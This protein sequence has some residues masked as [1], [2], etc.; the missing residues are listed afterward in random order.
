MGRK[1]QSQI[2]AATS[3]LPGFEPDGQESA[4]LA[5]GQLLITPVEAAPP[6]IAAAASALVGIGLATATINPIALPDPRQALEVHGSDEQD[7]VEPEA[8]EAGVTT[9]PPPVEEVVLK[10]WPMFDSA[11]FEPPSGEEK[12][13]KTNLHAIALCK[14]LRSQSV[15]P[16]DAQRHELLTY[17]GWGGLARVFETL[18][19]NTLQRY[20]DQLTKMLTPEE[21]A[22]ARAS[23]TD[24]FYTDPV[25]V[26]AMWDIVQRMGFK[27][28][29]IVEPT[30]GT[31]MFLA[32]MPREIAQKSEITAVEMDTVSGEIL[33]TVFGGLGVKTHIDRIERANVPYGFYDLCISN[34]PFGEQKSLETRKVGYADFSL[35]NYVIAK[36]CDLVRA[37]GLVVVVTSRF[38]MD[39]Q[40]RMHRQWL[41]AHAELLGAIRLPR[42]AFKKQA[43]TDV[44]TDIIV[45]RKRAAPVFSDH[46]E[47]INLG[48]APMEIMRPG[49]SLQDYSSH[50]RGYV[51]KPR[52]INAY[53]EKHPGMVVGQLEFQSGRYG[54]DDLVPVFAG[55]AQ[56]YKARLAECV[57][58]MPAN[59]YEDAKVVPDDCLAP[60]GLLLQRTTATHQVKPG[61]FVLHRGAIHISEGDSW[62]DVDAAYKGAARERLLGLMRLR[63]A[64]RAL[65]Q[66]QATST[67]E[68]AFRSLQFQLNTVYDGFVAKYGHMSDRANVR[69]FR[70]DPECPLILSLEQFDEDEEVYRKA[71]IFTKR[72]VGHREPPAT[73]DTTRDAMLV[74]LAL[75]GRIVLPDMAK[76]LGISSRAVVQAIVDEALAYLDPEDGKWRPADEY[77]SGHIRNKIAIATAAGAKYLR[78]VAALTAVL[79]KDLGPGEVEVRLGAPWVPAGVLAQF[80][81]ELIRMKAGT[82]EVEYDA[83]SATWTVKSGSHNPEWAGDRTLNTAKWG[84]TDRCAVTL[85]E[86]A[87]NQSPPK[88]TRTGVDKKTYVDRQATLAAR[89]KFEAIKCEFKQWAY[90]DEARRDSLLRMYN[91]EFNQIVER[92]YDGSHL[93]L[94][95][96]SKVIDPYTHQLSAIWRIVSG[97]NTLLAHVVGGGKTFTMAAA[98]ME[99]R[100]IGKAAKPCMVV[101]NHMLYDFT[102]DVVRFYPNAKIL[103]ASK[104]DL[105][106]DKRREFVAR[107]ALGDWDAV[108]MTHSTFERLPLRP[109]TAHKFVGRL[110]EQARLAMNMA[111]EAGS[112]RTVKQ[113]EKLIKVFEAKIERAMAEGERD[114]F[115]YWDDLGI[116]MIEYDEAHAAKN[117]LR[118]SKM[119]SIAGL[120]NASS[121]RAFDLWMKTSLVMEQRGDKEE[122]VVLST[123]TPLSNSLAEMHVLQKYLQPYTLKRLGLY[124]FDS[125]A[126]T[127]GESTQSLELAPD[128]SG[129]RLQSRFAK[130]VNVADLMAI[131]RCVADIRTRKMVKLPTPR[132]KGGK[133]QVIASEASTALKAYV[134]ELVKRANA[135]RN[136]SVKP[137]EDNMLSITH[138]G[139]MA[140]LDMR[141]VDFRLP[142]DESG[143]VARCRDEVMRI[144]NETHDRRGTQ[145]VFCD[146]ST[147]HTSGFS[148]YKDLEEK[149][150]ATGMPPEQIEF[151][152]DHD[153]DAAKEALFKKVRA[154]VV[155]VL[156]GSTQKLGIGTNVQRRLKAVHSLD[157]PWRPA[158]L[159]Q[160]D[161][162]GERPGNTWDEIE[163]LRYVTTSSFDAYIYQLIEAKARFIE[164][165]MTSTSGLR[166][167]EDLTVGAL[168]YAEIKAIASGNPVVLE[169]ATID[170]QVLRYTVLQDQHE[171]D[172]WTWSRRRSSNTAEIDHIEKY[173]DSDRADAQAI[174]AEATS[175]WTFQPTGTPCE[176]AVKAKS[177]AEQIGAQVNEVHKRVKI[178]EAVVGTVAGMNLVLSRWDGVQLYVASKKNDRMQ[179]RIDRRGVY[180]TQF[181][182]TGELVLDRLRGLIDLPQARDERVA[183]LR[184]ENDDLGR[185][186]E[187][188]FEHSDKLRDLVARQREIEAVLD[189]D[190]NEAGTEAV[191]DGGVAAETVA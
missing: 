11:L 140:A 160:R 80:L 184:K 141:L 83:Q 156:M 133:A 162:R 168:S 29:R 37:G 26:G 124:E 10:A 30:S 21:F 153:S 19:R 125:W 4:H 9:E 183:Q 89:E 126:G 65:L 82:A 99:M 66:Q 63:D 119:P 59:I 191:P 112:K 8:I 71:D 24:A 74:S 20:Q 96:M 132:I 185:M 5:P 81:D 166:T 91:D 86:N 114:D 14:Q 43:G 70:S 42:N 38:T 143:K 134:K 186:L 118:I 152:H 33:E 154:G 103:M 39:S 128:G 110:I 77:L 13:I 180:L 92:V 102:A 173:R 87:L 15:E 109:T 116:D 176:A 23:T 120:P 123:A 34:V 57:E 113:C 142:F 147:P 1:S 121:N 108:I 53:Y 60:A 144:W 95:G 101:P 12:R 73:V 111:N 139:R 72:T 93:L 16:T 36:G 177:T 161:G 131:F 64:A 67:D 138:C 69:V 2:L 135:V 169:K 187:T 106:G 76:R 174:A 97:G 190:K 75:Y 35:H 181:A 129:Y 157:V 182:E 31:G 170:A 50:T 28:G 25:V 51:D 189:L 85:M 6:P 94:P 178:G 7:P 130:F 49:Q 98:A 78:N 167:V 148:V 18:D 22:S 52:A 146:M 159:E 88:I 104:E 165:I 56:Q 54:R 46:G 136:R 149:L 164:Q 117:L 107:I 61:S 188:D 155:R 84:T 68:A 171:Q 47:W 122:G 151:I 137:H 172:R 40:T 105:T 48:N 158:D 79:P 175:G 62:I 90:R 3:W 58:V 32:G 44:I 55:D 145:V 127:F 100:R 150:V 163:L 17:V 45:L 41:N 115:V 27:G 179:I